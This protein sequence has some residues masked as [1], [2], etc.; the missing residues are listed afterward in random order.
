MDDNNYKEKNKISNPLTMI[1]IFAGL[2]ETAG[3]VV[4]PLIAEPYQKFFIW[5]VMG[6]PVLLVCLFFYVLIR[7][8]V[9]LYAPS[10][11]KDEKIFEQLQKRRIKAT[12]ALTAAMIKKNPDKNV[13]DINVNEITDIVAKASSDLNSK[14]LRSKN[15]ILWVDDTPENNLLERSVFE[16]VGLD[17]YTAL[18]TDEALHLLQ[19]NKYSVIISDMSRR[20]GPRAGYDLLNAMR[21]RGLT[22]P[23]IIYSGSDDP[24][25][26]AEAIRSGAQ[27]STC[28]A[29]ELLSL[30][31]RE[32][33]AA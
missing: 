7:H 16:N 17:V 23:F 31:M 18:S 5:Y 13:S 2:S 14:A 29:Q 21:E 24:A 4:L 8:P 19:R 26:T 28:R 9:N 32:I 27:G 10:D 20:E 15:K 30:V 11:F 25:H 3:A 6:F 33:N 1:G 12:A 22:L